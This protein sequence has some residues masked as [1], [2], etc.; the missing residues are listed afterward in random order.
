MR[1]DE[2]SRLY[3]QIEDIFAQAA[4]QVRGGMDPDA[5]TAFL[6]F[7]IQSEI[8]PR[9]QNGAAEK[10]AAWSYL[11][12][13]NMA[14]LEPPVTPPVRCQY[15]ASIETAGGTCRWCREEGGTP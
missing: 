1:Y 11:V 13:R 7:R 3:P 2:M 14:C 12:R 6:A 15:C 8:Q 10:V 5:V 9:H 4:A